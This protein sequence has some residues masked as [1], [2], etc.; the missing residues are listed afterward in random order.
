MKLDLNRKYIRTKID[1]KDLGWFSISHNLV[2][3]K[4]ER[5]S[6]YG[7]W[8]CIKAN[9]KTIYRQL[10]FNPTLKSNDGQEQIA[11]DWLGTIQLNNYNSEKDSSLTEYEIR[12]ANWLESICANIYH[13]D[14]GLRAAYKLG[15]VSLILGLISLVISLI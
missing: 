9:R 13:P 14:Q 15:I 12:Q 10:K 2:K 8:F 6:L 11:L 7:K 5:R 4:N 1:E 3:N